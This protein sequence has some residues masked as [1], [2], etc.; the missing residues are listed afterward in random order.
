[1]P[2]RAPPLTVLPACGVNKPFTVIVPAMLKLLLP[3]TPFVL[4]IVRLFKAVIL[5]G[6]F[7][8]TELPPN[9]NEEEE[10]VIKLVAVPAIVGPFKVNVFAPKVKVGAEGS[11]KKRQLV[12]GCTKS[13]SGGE[14]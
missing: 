8:P 1:M 7:T 2:V 14:Q 4:L 6:M 13:P 11:G 5:D 3:V 9:D 10:V 12:Y